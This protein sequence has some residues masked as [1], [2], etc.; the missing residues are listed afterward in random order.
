MDDFVA[1][2]Y[3]DRP[4]APIEDTERRMADQPE[5]EIAD[6]EREEKLAREEEGAG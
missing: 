3:R 4:V 5:G 1:I 2:D 6:A